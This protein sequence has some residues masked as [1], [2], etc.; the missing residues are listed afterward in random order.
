M[1]QTE[2]RRCAECNA[3][4]SAHGKGLAGQTFIRHAFKPE[5]IVTTWA[6]R[7]YDVW[8]NR[9]DGY[10]VNNV[11]SA[12][13]TEITIP[14]SRY[15]VGTASE[16]VSASPTDKQIRE[17]FG[18]GRSVGIETDGDDLIIYV[19]RSRDSYPLGEINCTSHASLSPI[20]TVEVKS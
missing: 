15:N 16:F 9:R 7:T 17:I 3:Y 11:F 8:G 4:E 19:N 13:R 1:N 18:L 10:E 6:I 12:G 20:K 5:M 14:C 2:I